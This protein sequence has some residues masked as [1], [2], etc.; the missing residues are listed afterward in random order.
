MRYL[1]AGRRCSTTRRDRSGGTAG[2]SRASGDGRRCQVEESVDWKIAVPYWAWIFEPLVRNTF[3]HGG[4][5]PGPV[6][7]WWCPDDSRLASRRS[8]ARLGVFHVAS[9]MLYAL[10]A[11]LLTFIAED[12][13]NGTRSQQAAILAVS[14]IGI[15]LTLRG[16]PGE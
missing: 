11:Q 4:P 3:R 2:P 9:G 12:L 15:V 13:G 8:C 1:N 6:R 10:L 14:R 16:H 7:G 5:P